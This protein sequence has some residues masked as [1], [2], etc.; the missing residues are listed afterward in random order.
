M[1]LNLKFTFLHGFWSLLGNISVKVISFIPLYILIFIAYG[2]GF[3]PEPLANASY[4]TRTKINQILLGTFM[5]KVID[6][7]ENDKYNHQKIDKITE[8]TEQQFRSG[9]SR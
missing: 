3:L 1:K 8:E 6:N 5:E 9:N 2:D 4:Q 7:I